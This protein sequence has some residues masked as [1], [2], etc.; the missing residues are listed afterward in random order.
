MASISYSELIDKLPAKH[1]PVPAGTYT[2]QA[3]MAKWTQA[4]SGRDMIVVTLIIESGEYAGR[5]LTWHLTIVP[6]NKRS[7]KRFFWYLSLLGVSQDYFAGEPYHED[8]I[9]KIILTGSR[10][11]VDIRE[12]RNA[13]TDI[14]TARCV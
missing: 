14:I 4:R 9:R 12:G 1:L 8:V 5:G 7:L 6:E 3:C 10:L 2:T 11:I 13:F